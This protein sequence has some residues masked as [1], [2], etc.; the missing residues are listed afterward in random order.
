MA[1]TSAGDLVLNLGWLFGA[2]SAVGLT[3]GELLERFVHR[4]YEAAE[5]AF[6]TILV[7]HGAIVLTVCQQVLGDAHAAEDAF[8]ATFLIMLRRSGSLRVREPGSLGPWLHRV[9]YLIA[10]KARQETARRRRA[11]VGRDAVGREALRRA[12]AG[13]LHALLHEEVNRLPAK[14]RAPLVL[15]YFERRT[16][17]EAAAALQ[18]PVCTVRSRLALSRYLLQSPAHPPRPVPSALFAATLL[19]PFSRLQPPSRLL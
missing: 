3:D 12:R 4:R 11:S 9:A 13:E 16:H 2:G 6:E 1:S 7:R 5:T 14:Y 10:L 18:W 8:Q 17:Y 19:Q 15:C